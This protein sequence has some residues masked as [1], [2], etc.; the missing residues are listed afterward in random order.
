MTDRVD[1]DAAR[2]AVAEEHGDAIVVVLGGR[3]W[4]ATRRVPVSAV[5]HLAGVATAPDEEQAA[6]IDEIGTMLFGDEQWPELRLI[7]DISELIA[8]TDTIVGQQGGAS[9]SA[10]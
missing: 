9:A 8:I 10:G 2:A 1:L 5:A 4:A 6:A 7:M 3:E